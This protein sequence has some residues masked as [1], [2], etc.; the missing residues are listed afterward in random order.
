[1]TMPIVENF[2][3]YLDETGDHRS[4]SSH[5]I[6]MRYLGLCGVIFERQKSD[7]FTKALE[8][9]KRKH[10]S[11]DPDDPPILHRKEIVAAQGSFM[12]LQDPG[13]RKSFDEELLQLISDARFR[14]VIVV[15]DKVDHW[16]KTY[17]SLKHPYHYCLLGMLERYCGW[18]RFR[19]VRG[20]VLAESRSGK[21]DL[22][23]KLAYQSIYASGGGYLT[24]AVCRST[25]TS[26]Q[27]KIKPKAI[28]IAGLQ[29]ADLLAHPL[30]R[31]V[32][33]QHGRLSSYESPFQSEIIKIAE[34]KYNRQFF[35]NRVDGYGRI[36]LH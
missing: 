3:L 24:A 33:R 30:T 26:K 9:F 10:L 7:A 28:N 15:L 29:L 19:S 23:L 2:R 32:L 16:A 17:R 11:Y 25:L 35:N 12:V 20:D 34:S 1:M 36:F 14:V 5:D 4:I 31:D 21:E 8:D 13:V 6:S 22:S 18:L 27:I